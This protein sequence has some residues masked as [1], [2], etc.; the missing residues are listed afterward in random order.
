[1]SSSGYLDPQ[2]AVL[3]SEVLVSGTSASAGD[4]GVIENGGLLPLIEE[5]TLFIGGTDG[6]ASSPTWSGL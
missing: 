4:L 1:M 5:A 3:S 6:G 2:T